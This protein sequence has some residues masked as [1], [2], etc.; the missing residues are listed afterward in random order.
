MEK[1]WLPWSEL[2]FRENEVKSELRYLQCALFSGRRHI[3]SLPLTTG[4]MAHS[5]IA[6]DKAVIQVTSLVSFMYTW[7]PFWLPSDG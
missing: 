3:R 1:N 4:G 7:L 5:F 2:R 6:L